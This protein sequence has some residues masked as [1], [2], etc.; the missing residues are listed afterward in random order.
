MG[1]HHLQG[2][3]LWSLCGLAVLL[4]AVAIGIRLN[5]SDAEATDRPDRS[6]ADRRAEA[7]R[8]LDD[9]MAILNAKASIDKVSNAEI[10]QATE[11]LLNETQRH[12]TLK[13]PPQPAPLFVTTNGWSPA[14]TALLA[15]LERVHEHGLDRDAFGLDTLAKPPAV[16][17]DPTPPLK[18]TPEAR[19][20]IIDTLSMH[21][22]MPNPHMLSGMLLSDAPEGCRSA[23]CIV[24]LEQPVLAGQFELLRATRMAR[25]LELA[26]SEVRLREALALYTTRMAPGRP[27][28]LPLLLGRLAS[29]THSRTQAEAALEGLSP[30]RGEYRGLAQ[31]LERYRGIARRGGWGTVELPRRLPRWGERS[32]TVD[33]LRW[34]LMAE[35][36]L[37]AD[38]EGVWDHDLE[39]ALRR[40]RERYG[41]SAW[42][43]LDAELVARLNVPC[44]GRLAQLA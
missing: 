27:D 31:A 5:G 43:G 42:G 22:Q 25:A 12:T 44:E 24:G 16:T 40:A 8:R 32:T 4:V 17:Q 34:R 18:L 11:A 1:R 38:P 28:T 36:L 30:R 15:Q 41:L 35:G 33:A 6:S 14:A 26:Q 23:P 13:V 9:A 10:A 37:Q 2:R 19:E 20:R 7:A 29:A 39:A 21:A 3:P